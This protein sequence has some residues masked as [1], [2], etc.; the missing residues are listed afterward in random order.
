MRRRTIT[1]PLNCRQVGKILQHYLDDRLDPSR[2]ALMDAHLHDCRRCGM[3]LDAYRTLCE[4]LARCRTALPL[5]TVQR[6]RDFG[7]RIAQDGGLQP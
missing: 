5:D 1:K 3:E 7:N 4:E 6:L 2:R